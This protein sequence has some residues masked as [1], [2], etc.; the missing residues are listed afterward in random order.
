MKEIFVGFRTFL[1]RGNVVE[2]AVAVV[3]GVAFGA[4]IDSL[5]SDLLTPLIA[6]IVGEPSFAALDFEINGAVFRYGAFLDAV[7]AFICVAAA[8]YFFVVVPMDRVAARM[9]S[10][11]P[12]PEATTKICPECLSGIPVAATRCAFC[13]Q[14][15]P[16]VT[17]SL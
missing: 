6:M 13:T 8:I 11:Q 15:V 3:I 10:G 12:D 9:R 5:V 1:M 4:V 7:F 2:L 14:P 17:A 16:A